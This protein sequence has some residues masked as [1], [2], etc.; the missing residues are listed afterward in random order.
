MEIKYSAYWKTENGHIR[1]TNGKLDEADIKEAI[2]RKE[3][4]ETID[5]IPVTF[6]NAT[7]DG[8]DL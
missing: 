8:V 5:H 7:F 6:T 1:I 2:E 3:A 4:R